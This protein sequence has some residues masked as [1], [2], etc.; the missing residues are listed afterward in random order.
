MAFQ[1]SVADGFFTGGGDVNRFERQ[2]DFDELFAWG[3][4]GH[5][6]AI[7]QAGQAGKNLPAEKDADTR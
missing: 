2:G 7:L 1:V 4:G 3:R 6:R 5:A